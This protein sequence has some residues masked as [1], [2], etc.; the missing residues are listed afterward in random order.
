MAERSK[1]YVYENIANYISDRVDL[2][3]NDVRLMLEY[4]KRGEDNY[5]AFADRERNKLLLD[6]K[7]DNLFQFT[8]ADYELYISSG[9]VRNFDPYKEYFESLPEVV[10]DPIKELASYIGVEEGKD[11]SF[12][13]QL[14]KWLVRTVKCAL[15]PDYYNKQILVFVCGEQHNGK[16]TLCRWLCPPALQDYYS[17]ETP[18]GKDECIQLSSNFLILYDELVKLNKTSESEVKA[19]LSKTRLKYRPPYDR[20]E[21]IFNRRCSFIGTCNE[22][23]FLTDPTGNVRF[24]AFEVKWIDFDY[25]KKLSRNQIWAQAYALYKSGFDCEMNPKD[26]AAQSEY[27]RRFFTTSTELDL[28]Q[29]YLR[30]AT[31]ADFKSSV[32]DV[33]LWQ[34][35]Q[36]LLFLQDCTPNIKLNQYTLGRGLKYQGFERKTA[37]QEGVI[38]YVYPV[39][40]NDSALHVREDLKACRQKK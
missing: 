12:A 18:Q 30:P 13:W 26:L 5:T 19:I 20:T 33:Y 6:M 36:I 23:Q 40:L 28:I 4:R 34:A 10:G 14:R 35:G 21:R 27:N 22:Q 16:T 31:E 17:E 37:R 3:Y 25:K 38:R 7:E 11:Y 15:E 39:V 29:W 9:R 8:K 2:R 32:T 1:N 24:L